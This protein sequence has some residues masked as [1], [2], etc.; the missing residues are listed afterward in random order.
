MVLVVWFCLTS[1]AN[2]NFSRPID[3]SG[4]VGK[5]VSMVMTAAGTPVIAYYDDTGD[6]L[7]LSLC[8]DADCASVTTVTLDITNDVGKYA[9]VALSASG[10]PAVAY[11]DD[12]LDNL[13][14]ALCQDAL[15]SSVTLRVLDETGVVG[16]YVSMALG[17]DG[18]L[19]GAYYD[20][21]NSA[22]KLF[23]CT[24]AACT[25]PE[26]IPMAT[27][28]GVGAWFS[29]KI[30]P[31][32]FPM[33]SF[34][35]GLNG[36]LRLADCAS[37]S[38]ATVTYYTLDSVD[39]VGGFSTLSFLPSTRPVVAYYDATNA[40]L[41]LVECQNLDCSAKSIVIVDTLNTVGQYPSMVIGADGFPLIAYHDVSL[42]DLKLADCAS[43]DCT[44]RTTAV[45]DSAAGA[46]A[47]LAKDSTSEAAIA[48]YH[49]ANTA[50]YLVRLKNY[51]PELSPLPPQTGLAAQ[52]LSFTVSA[53]DVDNAPQQTL[54]YSV[55]GQVPTGATFNTSTGLF[56]WTPTG[57]QIGTYV[58]VFFARDNG[59]PSLSDDMTVVITIEST[60]APPVLDPIGD[61]IVSEAILNTITLTASDPD[62]GQTL[63]Y[64]AAGLPT[65]AEL[66][67]STGVL[68][69]TP[70]PSQ[71]G[72][73]T[74]TFTVTDS[75]APLLTDSETVTIQ[76][77]DQ[78]VVNP[79]LNLDANHDK[80]PDGWRL[81]NAPK[82]WYRCESAPLNCVYQ[83]KYLASGGLT[84]PLEVRW[85]DVGDMLTARAM[86]RPRGITTQP[87]IVVQ[88]FYTDG[89]KAKLS[90]SA[91]GDSPVFALYEAAPLVLTQR[92]YKAQLRVQVRA[93]TKGMLVVDDVYVF[94]E[95]AGTDPTRL[96]AVNP[97]LPLP[98][99]AW[100]TDG[101]R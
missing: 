11:F 91:G 92:P 43:S 15:C 64:S 84:Q 82:S 29:L 74:V 52:P 39:N 61:L 76:V 85:L 4:D 36:D 90:I 13:K 94:A 75:G 49:A 62:A 2:A 47:W 9:S 25:S 1:A 100:R 28:G 14:L 6:D 33:I 53:T 71:V 42:S 66:N 17:S 77:R 60:N 57:A 44:S 5:Y 68:S 48:Y 31:D 50:L 87:V 83:A 59:I 86:L 79:T 58:L 73:H 81:S 19:V 56:S 67:P 51:A 69:W 12:T 24:D 35:D 70:S 65:D 89:S 97:M 54:T 8:A 3:N 93:R 63:T 22:M 20:R 101:G 46:Y 38:C 88:L 23:H 99:P 98:P 27:V 18:L 95:S 21:T 34:Y 80:S 96:G 10:F 55:V 26:L 7:K 41:K 32:N 30:A 16:E 72:Y 45:V 78:L 40:Q 37:L